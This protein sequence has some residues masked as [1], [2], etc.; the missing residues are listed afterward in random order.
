MDFFFVFCLC[1]IVMSVSCSHVVTCWKIADLMALLYVSFC[2]VFV[3]FRC[4]VLGQVWFLI[5][6]IPDLCRLSYFEGFFYFYYLLI[7]GG[8]MGWGSGGK[9]PYFGPNQF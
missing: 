7:L 9:S 3:T 1:H 5:S 6:L 4:G 2:C 8:R